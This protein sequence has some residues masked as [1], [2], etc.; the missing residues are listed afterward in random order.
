MFSASDNA[1]SAALA[2][3]ALHGARGGGLPP[4]LREVESVRDEFHQDLVSTRHT[5]SPVAASPRGSFTAPRPPPLLAPAAS[6]PLPPTAA[7]LHAARR[8]PLSP[9]GGSSGRLVLHASGTLV[10]VTASRLSFTA[11]PGQQDAT[12]AHVRRGAEGGSGQ[13]GSSGRS[14][15]YSPHN[16]GSFAVR[17][18]A[19]SCARVGVRAWSRGLAWVF[20]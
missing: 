1:F 4:A 9:T 13:A 18:R 2:S 19:C 12:L 11:L 14:S 3:G 16:S 8:T 6:A 7:A 10:P 15:V 17:V 20:A 5:G